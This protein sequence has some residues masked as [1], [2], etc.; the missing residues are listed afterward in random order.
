[1][2]IRNIDLNLL[3]IFVTVYECKS[4][5][6]AAKQLHLSQPAVS[7]AI[8]RLNSVLNMTLFVKNSR[9]IGPTPQADALYADVKC[10]LEK[11]E[12]ALSQ[13]SHFNPAT[14]E[15][16][17]RIA[18]SNYGEIF[19]FTKLVPYLQ[20]YAPNI[21]IIREFSP[22]DDFSRHLQNGQLDFGL[23]FDRPVE[24]D[25]HKECLGY[26]SLVLITGPQH[27]PLP[28]GLMF[29]DI[30]GLDFISF[31]NECNN[32]DFLFSAFIDRPNYPH[33]RF[34]VATMW[35]AYFIVSTTTLAAISPLLYA[36]ILKK[37]L[38]IKV[39]A[40]T[41]VKKIELSLYWHDRDLVAQDAGHQWLKES[42][43][44]MFAQDGLEDVEKLQCPHGIEGS[45]A[46]A[47]AMH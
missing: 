9:F 15:R 11:I 33:P 24:K 42:I 34:S 1:M 31:K 21:K 18:T 41:D 26:D 25:M 16:T 27:P 8:R 3:H 7:N 45:D 36:Q 43:K 4:I 10:C 30:A 29:D 20:R 32:Y 14:S 39:H 22:T 40:L 12:S 47:P 44:E 46:V 38:P 19:L 5:T 17:F 6:L 13:Q 2:K 23:F 35:S 37:H 28:D